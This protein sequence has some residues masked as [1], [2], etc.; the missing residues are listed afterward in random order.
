MTQPVPDSFASRL[1]AALEPMAFDDEANSWALLVY[2]IALG[3]M[4]QEIDDYA[5]DGPNGEPGWSSLLDV[6]LTPL[7]ALPWLGQFIGV[8]VDQKLS[9]VDQRQQVS[10]AGGWRRGTP[11]SL[12]GAAQPYLTGNKTVIM[13][14][15][16][17][18]ASPAEPAY[19]LS[20]ITYTSE[21][22]DS[23][24]VEAALIAQKPAG[25]VLRYVVMD[26]QDFQSLYLNNPTMQDVFTTYATFQGVVEAQ[27]GT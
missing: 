13:R 21:T 15:R 18:A 25:I 19:G 14:E 27:P 8:T 22:P 9:E 5:S 1:Y 23:A 3:T 16:D 10:D 4:F 17:P 6:D 7:K 24:A 20:V 26:G 12:V 2:C 11:A